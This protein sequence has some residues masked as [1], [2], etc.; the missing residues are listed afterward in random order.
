MRKVLRA[1]AR[2]ASDDAVPDP[3]EAYWDSF[4]QRV[5]ARIALAEG[6]RQAGARARVWSLPAAAAAIVMIAVAAASLLSSTGVPHLK[7]GVAAPDE[8]ADRLDEALELLLSR[9]GLDARVADD[10]LGTEILLEIGDREILEAIREIDPPSGMARAWTD[11][12]LRRQI[13]SLDE[14]H[15]RELREQIAL[16]PSS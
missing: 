6:K 14:G 12:D 8:P 15:L 3:G 5:R 2:A 10:L 4:L 16:E 11:E 1:M 7:T 13:E 9:P